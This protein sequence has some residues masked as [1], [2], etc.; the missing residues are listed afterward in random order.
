MCSNAEPHIRG[1]TSV[2]AIGNEDRK[3]SMSDPDGPQGIAVCLVQH[4]PV[5]KAHKLSRNL[6]RKSS[7]LATS[8]K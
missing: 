6:H 7:V 4:E 1:M 2:V 3:A 5:Q 8:N